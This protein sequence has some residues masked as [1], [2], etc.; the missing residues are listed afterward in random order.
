MEIAEKIRLITRNTEEC[1]STDRLETLLASGMPIKHYMGFEISGQVHIGQGMMTAM[2]VADF[3]KAG[4]HCRFWLADW[5]TWINDKLGGDRALIRQL[6][7]DYFAEALRACVTAAGGDASKV[8]ILLASDVYESS[9]TFWPT[10]VEVSKNINLA[11]A[12]RNITVMGRAEGDSVDLAKL[13]YA[14]MQ[15]ADVFELGSHIAH[16]GADQRKA[17]VIALDVAES[18]TINPLRGAD[19]KTIKPIA[20]HHP[21]IMGLGKITPWPLPEGASP[22]DIKASLKMSKSNPDSAVFV[23]D[24]PDDIRKKMNKAFCLEGETEYNAVLEWAQ[25]LVFGLNRGPLKVVREERHGGPMSLENFEELKAVFAEK[26]LHP[27]DLKACVGQSIVDLLEPVR[28]YFQEPAR[29]AALE[30]MRAAQ[31]KKK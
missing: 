5:H 8:E 24:S 25:Y 26:K 30:R 29:A 17:Q 15:A 3:Q 13:L 9:K 23:T 18:L 1:I 27:A 22:K 12:Q 28:N 20:I 11:R 19:G 4:I 10:V 21:L 31:Q 2:K 14:P 16:A 7:T 6:A